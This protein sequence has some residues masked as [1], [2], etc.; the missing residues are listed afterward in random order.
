V[1]VHHEVHGEGEP[2]VLVHGWGL[3]SRR[4]WIDTGWVEALTAVHRQVLLVDIRGHGRSDKPHD[5]EVYGYR[6]MGDD[7]L[8]SMDELGLARA[9]YLGYSLGAFVG[10][11]LLRDH[12][13]RFRSMVLGGIGEETEESAAAGA[14]IAAALRADDP[15]T[16]TDPV[17]RGY[18][19]FVDLD[20]TN[21]RQAL[22]AAALGM[23]PDG[24]PL[25]LGGEGL[26]TADLDVLVVDGS[27]DH[28]YID[29]VD[30]LLDALRRGRLVVL[31]GA[32]HLTAVTDPRFRAAVLE[33][34]DGLPS[35]L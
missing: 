32:D 16:I 20:P 7:V 10:A 11:A 34:L 29:M 18:R 27:E 28:P 2:I 33:F 3:A 19:A 1:H 17:G 22:A 21:D 35:T 31:D 23:W 26:R 14:T 12:A 25:E 6:A 13:H 24:H 8:Q 9:D 5:P 15:A 30:P 4:T